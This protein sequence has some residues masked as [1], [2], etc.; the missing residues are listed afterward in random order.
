[1]QFAQI[2]RAVGAVFSSLAFQRW[3]MTSE[4]IQQPRRGDAAN[5]RKEQSHCYS[6]VLTPN[7]ASSSSYKMPRPGLYG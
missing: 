5:P 7:F 1:M 3:E 6:R 2:A 4:T